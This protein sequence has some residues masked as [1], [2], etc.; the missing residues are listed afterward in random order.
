MFRTGGRQT[1]PYQV[2]EELPVGS[3]CDEGCPITT[4]AAMRLSTTVERWSLLVDSV[5]TWP[6]G[7]PTIAYDRN[8]QLAV[9]LPALRELIRVGQDTVLDE[10]HSERLLLGRMRSLRC[11]RAAH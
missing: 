9:Q 8:L 3:L 4:V 11:A 2:V 10:E 1:F 6:I 5:L 7:L